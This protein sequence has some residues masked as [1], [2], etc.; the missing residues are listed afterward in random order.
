VPGAEIN[1]QVLLTQNK[2]LPKGFSTI[3]LQRC[4]AVF[5]YRYFPFMIPVLIHF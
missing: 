3:W 5:F 2:K 1:G 4:G